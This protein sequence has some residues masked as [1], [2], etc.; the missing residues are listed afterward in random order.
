MQIADSVVLIT[1]ASQGIGAACAAAFRRRG[2]KLALLARNAE[3]LQ[4]V[5]ANGELVLAGDVTD[6]GFRQDAVARTLKT[7]GAID[8]LINNA[9][10]GLYTP[11]WDATEGQV[12]SLFDLNFFAPLALAQL[13]IPQMR[14]RRR[15]MLVNIGSIAG[16]ITLPWFTLYSTSKH[17]LGALTAGLRM[18]L[19]RDGIRAMTV[20]PGYVDT[21]FQQHAI[22]GKPP[23][24]LRR[25]RPLSVTVE[26]CAEAVAHGVE[27]DA[28]TVVTPRTGWALIW[29]RRFFPATVDRFLVHMQERPA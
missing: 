23:A 29:S 22:A 8:V 4:A 24:A 15:G 20:C 9:G 19:Q 7:Y 13:V 10:A 16:E 28:R 27:R 2:A 5:A 18:E 17:A 26:E 1:G 12:R 25:S 14:Q 6:S 3:K 11:A 21:E